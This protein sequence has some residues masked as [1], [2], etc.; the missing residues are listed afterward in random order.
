[1]H[2]KLRYVS[3]HNKLV[4]LVVQVQ[5]HM[6]VIYSLGGGH[7]HRHTDMQTKAISRNQ[8]HVGLW[9]AHAW[10]KKTQQAMA[11]TPILLLTPDH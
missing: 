3:K 6:N 2:R 10:F 8:V 7:T 5:Y 11:N 9:P 4:Q 1:M